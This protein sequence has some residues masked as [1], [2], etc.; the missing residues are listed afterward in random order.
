[1]NSKK[2]I[3]L[4][5]LATLVMSLVPVLPVSAAVTITALTDTSAVPVPYVSG[6][7][8]VVYGDT[9]RIVGAGV[10]SGDTIKAYWDTV[11]AAYEVNATTGEPAGEYEIWVDIPSTVVGDHY[12]WIKDI[13]TGQTVRSAAITV[14]PKIELDIKEGLPN[15]DV[16]IS[17]YGYD[18]DEE[19]TVTWAAGAID[20][21]PSTV[22]SDDDGAWTATISVPDPSPYAI[23]AI[24]AVDE[25]AGGAN[26]ANANFE[27]GAAITLDVDEGPAGTV[28]TISGRGF[29]AATV[30]D[31]SI[32]GMVEMDT[33]PTTGPFK[34]VAEDDDTVTISAGETFT[35]SVIVPSVAAG[36]YEITVDDGPRDASAD[37]EVLGNSGIDI[38]PG[39]AAPGG[40]FTVSGE[41]Y[42]QIS[43]STLTFTVGGTSVSDSI[44]VE[45]DGTFEGTIIMPAKTLGAEHAVVATDENGLTATDNVLCGVL[46][47]L[48]SD[49]EGP[50]GTK[51]SLTA[52][53]LKG[54]L[55]YNVT[56]GGEKLIADVAAGGATSISDEFYIPSLAPGVHTLTFLD[57]GWDISVDVDV[58]VTE[59]ASISIT[60]SGAPNRYQVYI[61]GENWAEAEVDNVVWW[62]WNDTDEWDIT[63]KVWELDDN[64]TFPLIP[65]DNQTFDAYFTIGDVSNMLELGT[66]NINATQAITGQHAK[67]YIYAETTIDVVAEDWDISI[68]KDTYEV[69]DTITYNIRATFKKA[70][71]ELTITD[72]DGYVHWFATLGAGDWITVGDWQTVPVGYQIGDNSAS[73]FTLSEDAPLGTWTWAIEDG[74]DELESGSFEVVEP[75]DSAAAVEE[76]VEEAVEVAIEA[77]LEESLAGVT[78]DIEAL[79]DEIIDYSSEFDSVADDIA[80]VA[81]LAADAIDAAEAAADAVSSV[82]TVAGDAAEAAADAAEAATAAKDAATGLTTLVYGAIGAA[83]V[84]ALAAIVS[85]MQI[86]RRIAG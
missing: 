47:V 25:A 33:D 58:T 66:Y 43:G 52:T 6:T 50:V 18:D 35:Y 67:S 29:T 4:L 2:A 56:L 44:T 40:V 5:V 34:L 19:I 1:M 28:V 13:E 42:T 24:V 36:D 78:A 79:A 80:A 10:T 61:Y 9:M 53:G 82:A 48:L 68:K 73:P 86:S 45:A 71:A 69:G 59:A 7:D 12:V 23:Y 75:A 32:A 72:P 8:T 30:L 60:P 15:D 85:L 49:Y 14:D 11:G 51:V 84:A 37:F 74:D 3:T 70:G 39:Y 54:T 38:D 57:Q 46:T 27:V 41:N 31:A 22:E 81:G 26:T 77:A 55:N 62:L 83:L 76:A 21:S 65:W 20:T 64:T 16:V 63:A 17:G